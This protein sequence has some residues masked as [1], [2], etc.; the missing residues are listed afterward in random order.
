MVRPAV[1]ARLCAATRKQAIQ[2]LGDA[3]A[4]AA[5]LDPRAVCEAVLMRER[6]AGTGVG[7]GAAIPHAM[8]DGL[9]APVVGFARLE[10]PAN[11]DALDR[12]PADLVFMLLAPRHAGGDHLRALARVSRFVRRAEIREALRAARG[13]EELL[14]LLCEGRASDAA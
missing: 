11:F 10:H 4:Q 6:L 1:L 9:A 2:A 12:R 5:G 7:E 14:V 13:Q 8:V 3:L